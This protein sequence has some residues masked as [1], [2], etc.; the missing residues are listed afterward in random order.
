MHTMNESPIMI[1]NLMWHS[2]VEI[3]QHFLVRWKC[4][5]V[6]ELEA[7]L[8]VQLAARFLLYS[9]LYGFRDIASDNERN[10]V[11]CEG[12]CQSIC[13]CM[14]NPSKARSEFGVKIK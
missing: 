3:Y 4:L 14:L 12:E 7:K 11:V 6:V 8:N 9:S 2:F 5:A 1:S 13:R 10:I